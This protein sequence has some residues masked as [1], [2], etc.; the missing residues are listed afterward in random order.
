MSIRRLFALAAAVSLAACA[1][2]SEPLTPETVLAAD[3]GSTEH[4]VVGS[5]HVQTSAGLREFTFHAVE[6][7]QGGVS[8]SYKIQLPNGLFF[9]ADVT[10]LAVEGNTGWVG[11]TIRASNAGIV[12]IGSKSMFY[13]IDNGE[14]EGTPDVVS[15]AGFNMPEGADLAFCDERPLELPPLTVTD[16]NVQVD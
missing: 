9:E 10:C 4:R 2:A 11:G 12:V 7:P 14:G 13:A 5:G 1:E 8:G 3:P 16:G 15:V 6:S